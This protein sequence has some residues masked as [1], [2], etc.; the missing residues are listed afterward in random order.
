MLRPALTTYIQVCRQGSF[1][2]AAA[3]LYITPSAVMQQMDALEREYG[4]KLLTRTHHGVKPTEAGGYLLQ[5]AEA[6]ARRSAQVRAS[7][8]IIAAGDRMICVGTSL[9]EKCRLLYDLW[10]LYTQRNP[11]SRIQMVSIGAEGGIPDCVDMIESLN[12]G[13]GW[14]REWVFFEICRVPIGIAMEPSHPL[15][16]RAQ[17][18]P[19]DLAGREVVTF[20]DTTFEGLERL[21]A[22]AER[23]GVRW[24]WQDMPT[25]SVFWECVFE[26][27]LLLAP[28]CWSDILTGLT[29]RPVHWGYA[30]P[31]GI[32]SRVQPRGEAGRFMRFIRDT[33][34]G[35]GPDDILPVLTW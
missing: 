20:R 18:N 21:Y 28:L 15:A 26:R 3:R 34:R 22:S 27:R 17:L 16:A 10:T 31:Y 25:A 9:L 13:V 5:E 33:Y 6:L 12:G 8:D 24:R 23:L 4:V 7:L 35:S 30:L 32:F 19:M 2:R 14:M 11:E 29:V 1:T